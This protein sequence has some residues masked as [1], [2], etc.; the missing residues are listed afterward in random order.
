MAEWDICA[1]RDVARH[2][3]ELE[4]LS[5]GGIYT[6]HHIIPDHCFFYTSGLR[7]FGGG[8]DFLCPGVTNYHTDDAPVIIVTADF[9]GGKSR[10]HGMIHLE[11]DAEENRFQRTHRWEYQEARAAAIN[12]IM[13]NYAGMS[14][15]ALSQ[16]LDAYFKVTCGIRDTTYLRAGE[17]GTMPG[18]KPRTSPRTKR[19]QPY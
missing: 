10:N 6:G 2:T 15:V 18:I 14:E 13:F 11:F 3:S 1:Y 8:S 17:H 5:E 9:N 12:S 19:F 4:A 16:V 7:K